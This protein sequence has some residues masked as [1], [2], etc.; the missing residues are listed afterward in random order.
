MSGDSRTEFSGP[1]GVVNSGSGNTYVSFTADNLLKTPPTARRRVAESQ[2]RHLQRQFARPPHINSA[3]DVL[4]SRSILFLDGAP[5]SGRS[6]AARVLL[7]E[8]PHSTGT[9]HELTTESDEGKGPPRLSPD[10][11]GERD[12]MLLDL[13]AA[14]ESLWNTVQAQLWDFY[15]AVQKK[16]AH[17]AVVLPA[18]QQGQLAPEFLAFRKKIERPDGMDVIVRHLRCGGLDT[19]ICDP[20]PPVLLSFVEKEPPMRELALLADRILTVRT[21][22]HARGTFDAWCA[23]AV[24]AQTDRGPEVASLVPH[25]RKGPQRALLLASALLHGARSEA[26]HEAT[27]ALLSAVKAPVEV[28]PLLEHP[29]LDERL[30]KI[31]A[32]A[33]KNSRVTFDRLG[34]A[35]AVRRH[36]WTTRPDLRT[37]LRTWVA[38]V[39]SRP[40]LADT[41]R[42]N[43]VRRFTD[44][45]LSTHDTEELI[46]LVKSW[47][48]DSARKDQ[49]RAAAQLLERSVP[50][51]ACGG[52]LRHQL[53]EWSTRQLSDSLR[54]VL[55]EVCEKVMSVRHPEAA[56]VRLHHMAR[57]ERP[58]GV[59]REAL[60]RYVTNDPEDL[61]LHRRLLYRLTV[62]SSDSHRRPD[63][64]LFLDLTAPTRLPK[65]FLRS[66]NTRSWLTTGWASVFDRAE[67]QRWSACAD[68]WISAA[69]A[70]KDRAIADKLLDVLVGAA[71][72]RYAILNRLYAS[73]RTH[74]HP[75]LSALLLRKISAAQATHLSQDPT[76]SRQ[77]EAAPS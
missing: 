20:P 16:Q 70:T 10:N 42:D 77:Q 39:L 50:S 11:I 43:L 29:G 63:A 55:A 25:L 58:P 14:D 65:P 61:R 9:Y 37:P 40:E 23:Q 36:F 35:H 5:G 59:V 27:A 68:A 19:R 76:M 41:D 26:V 30:E 7:R 72:S 54:H 8:L 44:L 51:E 1:A 24:A 62:A 57:H 52:E 17:L 34:F 33:D 38:A 53:Y 2:L 28:R 32:A 31:D 12:R 3:Y 21:A 49:L 4:E 56:L 69:D 18:R 13:S 60:L 15:H 74:A 75:D 48:H 6:S 22:E 73:A 45:C 64:D 71:G 47:T 46:A 66:S 67:R